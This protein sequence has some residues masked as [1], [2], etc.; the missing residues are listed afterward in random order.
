MT[1]KPFLRFFSA[2]PKHADTP[3]NSLDAFLT[4]CRT[5]NVHFTFCGSD[6]QTSS[7][8]ALIA[9]L[10]LSRKSRKHL[11]NTL[12]PMTRFTLGPDEF[13]AAMNHQDQQAF[14]CQVC[15]SCAPGL[16]EYYGYNVADTGWCSQC[17]Q[18]G[19]CLDVPLIEY[20][21]RHGIDDDTINRYLPRKRWGL[22]GSGAPPLYQSLEDIKA[23]HHSLFDMARARLTL[24]SINQ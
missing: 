6:H 14:P 10:H 22:R 16:F 19:E 9:P 15:D 18:R 4:Q 8:K 24:H 1:I 17:H 5:Q 21:R 7:L 23:I 12:K 2:T 3:E 20:Y 13:F 11:L